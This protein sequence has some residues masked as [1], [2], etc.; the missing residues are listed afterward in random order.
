MP[1]DGVFTYS[2]VGIREQRIITTH[3]HLKV[4]RGLGKIR[5]GS[6]VFADDSV[7]LYVEIA[8]A[9]SNDA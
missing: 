5:L 6:A 7:L 3:K 1:D 8:E 4:L 9:V 2:E